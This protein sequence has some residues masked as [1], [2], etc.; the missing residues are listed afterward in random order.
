VSQRSAVWSLLRACAGSVLFRGRVRACERSQV[1]DIKERAMR[2]RARNSNERALRQGMCAR[3]FAGERGLR[4]A[5]IT[6]SWK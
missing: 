6:D 3:A 2:A 4:D 1:A 5:A